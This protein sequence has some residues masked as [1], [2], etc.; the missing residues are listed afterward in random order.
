MQTFINWPVWFA[1]GGMKR[2]QLAVHVR[3]TFLLG[4][5]KIPNENWEDLVSATPGSRLLVWFGEKFWCGLG[6]ALRMGMPKAYIPHQCPDL[7]PCWDVDG[8]HLGGCKFK[9]KSPRVR[10]V[11]EYW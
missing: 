9:E 4:L 10:S 8:S 6:G 11:C 3:P 7:A 5:V 2:L 1:V